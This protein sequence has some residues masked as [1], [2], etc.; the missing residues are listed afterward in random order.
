[1]W[2]RYHIKKHRSNQ[3]RMEQ[4]LEI[5]GDVFTTT[6]TPNPP[7]IGSHVV[8]IQGLQEYLQLLVGDA[9]PTESFQ[10]V[11]GEVRTA[12]AA[13]ND[14]LDTP[15]NVQTAKISGYSSRLQLEFASHG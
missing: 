7:I 14:W 10:Q 6:E 4:H 1:M 2:Y 11:L 15:L 8:P 13:P 12:Y 5:I 3:R 9:I